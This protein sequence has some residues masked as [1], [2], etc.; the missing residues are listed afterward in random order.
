MVIFNVTNHF[1]WVKLSD[2]PILN[3]TIFQLSAR[4]TTTI[5]P[6][7]AREVAPKAAPEDALRNTPKDIPKGISGRDIKRY[8]P[9]I[10]YPSNMFRRHVYVYISTVQLVK[11]IL[12]GYFWSLPT[13]VHLSTVWR[14]KDTLELVA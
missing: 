7:G 9:N 10:R 4:F 5:D 2:F 14:P 6:V 12:E 11:D 1:S 8:L 13:S 3:L